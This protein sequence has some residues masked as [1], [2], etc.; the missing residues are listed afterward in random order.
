MATATRFMTADEFFMMPNDGQLH[1]LIDGEVRTMS[2]PGG[3]HGEVAGEAF[4]LLSNHVKAH[5]LGRMY[6][7]ETG[8]LIRR[9]PD[10]V[11]AP[12]VGFVRRERLAEIVDRRKYVP[13]GPDLAVEVES[14]NDRPGEVAEKTR[15][16][17]AAGT[18][19]VWNIDPESR[20]ATVH[21]PDAPAIALTEDDFLDGEDVVPGFRCR[22]ADLFT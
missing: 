14:P 11:R 1:D 6:A 18:R 12:D 20:T 21:R 8:F 15:D 3:L 5:G 16:W 17:L 9:D 19:L 13:F 10:T 7:A 4:R 22:I 2:H